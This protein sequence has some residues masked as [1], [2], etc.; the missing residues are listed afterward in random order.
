MEV[1]QIIPRVMARVLVGSELMQMWMAKEAAPLHNGPNDMGKCTLICI[2][3]LTNI[4]LFLLQI[5]FKF[6]E[7]DEKIVSFLHHLLKD[8]LIDFFKL[9][10]QFLLKSEVF[11]LEICSIHQNWIAWKWRQN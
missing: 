5:D 6:N 9:S 4:Y 3:Y 10:F 11:E 1:I 8:I 2:F 7:I